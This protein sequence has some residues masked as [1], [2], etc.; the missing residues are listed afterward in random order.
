VLG[1]TRV[2]GA[3]ASAGLAWGLFESQ[4]VECRQIDV[5]VPGLP[6]ALDGLRILHLSDFHLGSVSLNGRAVRKAVAWAASSRTDLVAMTGDL[7]SRSRGERDL[8]ES[9]AALRW[10]HGAYAV[11]GNH[12]VAV[13]RDP[14]NAAHEIED[15]ERE[16]VALL[17]D[18]SAAVGGLPVHVQV[19]G[20]DPIEFLARRSRLEELA[21]PGADLR[22]LL[23]HFPEVVDRLPSGAFHLVLAGHVHGG[24]I[25]LP[26]P[27]GKIRFGG[28]RPPYPQGVFELAGTTLVVSR[29]TGTAF[30]PFRFFARPEVAELVLRPV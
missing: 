30:V 6:V 9:L 27:G 5:R 18:A 4:W 21:D 17:R 7:L 29:G 8:R 11:L 2:L 10:R 13:T 3:A 19:V 22:I 25:C 23:C 26:Y 14:F 28:F 15:L 20:A 1:R 12:D 16:G 24:Q